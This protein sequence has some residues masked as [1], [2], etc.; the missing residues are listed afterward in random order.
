MFC[1]VKMEH[2]GNEVYLSFK[3]HTMSSGPV[4]SSTVS[5]GASEALGISE[6]RVEQWLA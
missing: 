2:F 4:E 6:H 5:W 3:L 1:R